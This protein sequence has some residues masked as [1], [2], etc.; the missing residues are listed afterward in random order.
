MMGG[1]EGRREGGVGGGEQDF[2]VCSGFLGGKR[3]LLKEKVYRYMHIESGGR[4]G[5]RRKRR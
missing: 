2:L 4:E 3:E 5:G 1:R